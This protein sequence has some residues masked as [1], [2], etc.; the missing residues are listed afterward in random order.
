M[1]FTVEAV[2]NLIKLA[3]IVAFIYLALHLYL[4]RRRT[5][6][7]DKFNTLRLSVMSILTFAVAAIMVAEKVL[8]QDS[9]PLDKAILL[10][11]HSHVPVSL[12]GFFEAVTLTGSSN[13]LLILS[14][15][16]IATLLWQRWR[17]EA[18][19]VLTT[20]IIAPLTIY[21]LK[22][23][24]DRQR[25]AL[26]ETAWYW[27]SSFPSGHTLGT[28]AFASACTLC[29]LRLKPALHTPALVIAMLWIGLVGLSRMVL[30][31]HWPTDVL[32]AGCIGAFIPL[33]LNMLIEIRQHR[34]A[35]RLGISQ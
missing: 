12:H 11:L 8:D 32:A 22:A 28:T 24:V 16:V 25:P 4:H 27:G 23:L 30:G 29:V 17:T 33:A 14:T 5:Q 2:E 9:A 7:A 6:W 18:L 20:M 3:L 15:L 34:I 1:E 35:T 10:Y 26:W 31:V 13:G 21:V 19:L